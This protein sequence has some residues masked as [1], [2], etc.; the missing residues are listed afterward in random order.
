MRLI[1]HGGDI[2]TKN[3]INEL[4]DF[5]ANINPLGMPKSIADAIID[6]IDK[7]MCYPD[8]QCIELRTAIAH[9]FNVHPNMITCGNGAADIIYRIILALRPEKALILA[10]T[11]SEYEEALRLVSSE[12][13]YYYLLEENDFTIQKDIIDFITDDLDMIFICNPNNPTGIPYSKDKMIKIIEKCKEKNV[14]IVIDE[15]FSDFLIDEENYSV[16]S[17][18]GKYDNLI[19]LKAFTKMYA[20]AGIRLGYMICSNENFNFKISNML[21]P[22]SVSTIASKS[23]I[24]ALN[25]KDFVLRTKKYIHDNRIYLINSLRDLG[26]KVFDSEVNYILFKSDDIEIDKKLEKQGILIRSCSNY[27]N[28]G[29][30]FFRIAVKNA[31]DNKQLIKCLKLITGAD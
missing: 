8:C 24:A 13:H 31:D 9:S 2:Y 16:V 5:S 17:Q 29:N 1:K 11:F 27:I 10:P 7:Y 28:L 6:N 15:C 21:Q 12:I 20:M 3:N 25:E 30:N 22:W 23:G 19:I 18:V 14:T 26:Y 4:I